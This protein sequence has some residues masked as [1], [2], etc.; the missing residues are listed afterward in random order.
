MHQLILFSFQGFVHDHR[1]LLFALLIG[2]VA[3]LLAQLIVPGRGFGMIVTIILGMA[4]GWLGSMLF[5]N[6]LSFTHS[7]LINTIICATAG[8]IIL[9]VLINLIAGKDRRDKTAYRA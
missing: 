1:V 4:G 5:K 6:Y 9:C 7:N 8:A 2:A 3:G